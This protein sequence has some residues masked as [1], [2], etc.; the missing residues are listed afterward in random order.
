MSQAQQADYQPFNA[1]EW[2]LGIVVAQFNRHITDELYQ[3]ALKRAAEYN[4]H[5]ESID[6]IKVAG[7][8][9]IP[10]VLQRLAQTGKYNVL[11]AIGCVIRGETPH[12]DY[13]SKFV[14]EGVLKVQLSH[15]MPI[16]FGVLTCDNEEQAQA[17]IKL[18]ADHLDA[19]MHQAN[20]L[21]KSGPNRA[22]FD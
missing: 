4:L 20:V 17:R 1:G 10:L 2:R 11:L 14:T 12:F 6:T 21:D 3:S 13:V 15:D 18:G 7:A 22:L 5:E 19:V 8:V 9:E 16:G